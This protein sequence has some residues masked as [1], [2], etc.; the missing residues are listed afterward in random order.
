MVRA[1]RG[2]AYGVPKE[3]GLTGGE[4]SSDLQV[5]E[6]VAS[7]GAGVRGGTLVSVLG[8][9]FPGLQPPGGAVWWV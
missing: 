3:V 6:G 2:P 1:G 5:A 4:A 8:E 9:P 7:G